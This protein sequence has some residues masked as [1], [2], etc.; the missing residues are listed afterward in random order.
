[1]NLILDIT[2]KIEKAFQKLWPYQD[3]KEI[4]RT[5]EMGEEA[6]YFAKL[7][8]MSEEER[9]SHLMKA[10]EKGEATEKQRAIFRDV[11]YEITDQLNRLSP[12]TYPREDP[13]TPKL[14]Y[15]FLRRFSLAYSKQG[16]QRSAGPILEYLLAADYDHAFWLWNEWIGA[17]MAQQD[18]ESTESLIAVATD[19]STP[20]AHH[21]AT[22]A[23]TYKPHLMAAKAMIALRRDG[24]LKLAHEIANNARLTF[25]ESKVAIEAF[26]GI[27]YIRQEV[28]A[29]RAQIA[30]STGKKT[31]DDI[32]AL[33]DR[34]VPAAALIT[35]KWNDEE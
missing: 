29:G 5:R 23:G 12:E 21:F 6:N 18:F 24:D 13:E 8:H 17:Y 33:M 10:A 22:R 4:L 2:E 31:K 3:Q 35:G 30:M 26:R 27:E 9:Q 25:G 11:G 32:V 7:A 16:K 15:D 34:R 28:A 1:M 14:M 20:A 19:G